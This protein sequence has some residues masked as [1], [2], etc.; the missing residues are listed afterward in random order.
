VDDDFFLDRTV[1]AVPGSVEFEWHGSRFRADLP[2]GLTL[3]AYLL[4]Q[5]LPEPPPGDLVLVL[6]RKPSLLD[7]FRRQDL[8]EIEVA[9]HPLPR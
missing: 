7:L 3:P 8:A 2:S 6:R 9:A 5:D 1:R 4:V